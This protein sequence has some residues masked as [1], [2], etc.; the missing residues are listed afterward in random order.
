M[1]GSIKYQVS[2]VWSQLDGIGKSKA[3]HRKEQPVKNVDN[4]RNTSPLVHSYEYKDEIFKTARNL[5]GFAYKRSI[6]DM[7]K[8]PMDIVENWFDDK[9]E[10]N[11]SRN[12]LRNYLAHVVKIQIALEAIAKKEGH[13]YIGY[14]KEQLSNIHMTI[15]K[16]ERTSGFDRAYKNPGLVIG[17]LKDERMHFTGTLQWRYGLR[18]TEASHIKASQLQGNT[19]TYYGKGGF[20]QTAELSDEHVD[21]LRQ[22]MV[23]GLFQV[24]QNQYRKEL[25]KNALRM[26]EKYTGSHGLRYNFLQNLQDK[27][28]YRK[29]ADGVRPLEAMR[30]AR[31]AVS[32]A[33][34]H[35]RISAANA[36]IWH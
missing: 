30:I 22:L 21:R 15:K 4:T 6:K 20:V 13:D 19:L 26:H 10:K 24:N 36:Y 27:I 11:V 28:F 35:H 34:G 32:E 14:T 18:I 5:F 3:E 7:T 12:T 8:I 2:Q 29:I 1:H 31:K 33:A 17:I 9:V 23:D 16:M 25:E